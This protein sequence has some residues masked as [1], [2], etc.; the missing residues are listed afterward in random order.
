MKKTYLITGV[1]RDFAEDKRALEQ[2]K[3]EIKSVFQEVCIA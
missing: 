3:A 1:L 2:I